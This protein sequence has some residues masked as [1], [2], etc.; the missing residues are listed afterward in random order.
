M[1]RMHSSGKGI[2]SSA[3]PYKR[4]PPSWVKATSSDVEEH[5]CRLAK[6]GLYPSAVSRHDKS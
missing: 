3:I 5:V 1:G 6:K 4:T 2:A